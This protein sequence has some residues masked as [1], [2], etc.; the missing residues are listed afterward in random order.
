MSLSR[1]GFL[2]TTAAGA[3]LISAMPAVA[4]AMPRPEVLVL[5][6]RHAPRSF[7]DGLKA[8]LATHQMAEQRVLAG[9]PASVL[10]ARDWLAGGDGRALA[11]LV[12]DADAV[13]LEQL[14]RGIGRVMASGH[15]VEEPGSLGLR[16][17]FD[18]TPGA[19]P[20]ARAIGA[21]GTPHDWARVLGEGMA[22]LI[23]DGRNGGGDIAAAGCSATGAR[24]MPSMASLLIA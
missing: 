10:A 6:D 12:A 11:A 20:L 4:F 5:V 8:G 24:R 15:H 16:H 1:R 9:G 2:K 19:T 14:A 3:A 7:L 21:A 23:A 17:R 13:L 18:A 22:R